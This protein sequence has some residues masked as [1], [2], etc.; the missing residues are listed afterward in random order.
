MPAT[1]RQTESAEALAIEYRPID[2][3]VPYARKAHTHSKAQVALIA[4]G[5]TDPGGGGHL[6]GASR[7]RDRRSLIYHT[8]EFGR[9]VE[10]AWWVDGK[11]DAARSRLEAA[12]GALAEWRS[13]Q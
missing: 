1:L 9:G 5:F 12:L 8:R 7:G 10:R 11:T 3:L 4:L 13:D 2:S 6:L